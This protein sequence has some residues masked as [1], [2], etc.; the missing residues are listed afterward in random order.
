VG[1]GGRYVEHEIAQSLVLQPIKPA[2]GLSQ[3]G[4]R[5]LEILRHLAAG[6]SLGEIAAVLGIGYK[7]VANTCSLIKA[8]LGVTRTSDL[9]RLALDGGRPLASPGGLREPQGR[10][11]G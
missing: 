7:T 2:G 5:D 3:L 6:K 10:S 11:A 1:S 4:P 8:K 9:V